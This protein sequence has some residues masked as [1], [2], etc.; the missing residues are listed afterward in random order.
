MEGKDDTPKKSEERNKCCVR[1]KSPIVTQLR[2]NSLTSASKA[3][4]VP[5]NLMHRQ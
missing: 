5:W 2:E 4:V 3:V 1:K